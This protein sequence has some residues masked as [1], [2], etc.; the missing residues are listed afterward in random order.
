VTPTPDPSPQGGGE[1]ADF[2]EPFG[3]KN[4]RYLPLRHC[5]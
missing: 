3:I 5:A 4:G 1:R 2:A